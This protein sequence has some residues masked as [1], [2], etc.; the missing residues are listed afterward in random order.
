[1]PQRSSCSVAVPRQRTQQRAVEPP[2]SRAPSAQRRARSGLPK[3]CRIVAIH[4]P[5]K[6]YQPCSAKRRPFLKRVHQRQNAGPSTDHR[7]R[8]WSRPAIPPAPQ[9]QGSRQGVERR[10]YPEGHP[11]R[12]TAAES[13]IIT[14]PPT[15]IAMPFP[16]GRHAPWQERANQ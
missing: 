3:R 9:P 14:P 1:M 12:R 10:P 15:A 2:G 4:R 8:N 6:Y 11:R 16:A 13:A 5:I 7:H